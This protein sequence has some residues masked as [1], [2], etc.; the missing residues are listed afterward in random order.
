MCFYSLQSLYPLYMATCFVGSS[1]TGLS[2]A[3]MVFGVGPIGGLSGGILL[4]IL[5]KWIGTQG[6]MGIGVLTTTIFIALLSVAGLGQQ[7]VAM[8]LTAG[9]MFGIGMSLPF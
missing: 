1:A 8:G 5:S 2:E 4:P 7:A 6:V 9:A 3:Q